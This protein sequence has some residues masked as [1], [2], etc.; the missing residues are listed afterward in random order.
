VGIAPLA[1]SRSFRRLALVALATPLVAAIIELVASPWSHD[2][3]MRVWRAS[4]LG[5]PGAAIALGF[6]GVLLALWKPVRPGTLRVEER[7]LVVDRG[8]DAR[9]IPLTSIR[10]GVVVP[11]LYGKRARV[12]ITL[13]SGDEVI[14]EVE[15]V[16]EGA[17]LLAEAGIDA[18]RRRSSIPLRSP[19]KSAFFR[20]GTILA[21][22]FGMFVGLGVLIGAV[23]PIRPVFIPV[24]LFTTA[25]S[26][27]LAAHLMR[28]RSITV[29]ADGLIVP[30][31]FRDAFVPFS[32]ITSVSA[33]RSSV[34]ITLHD[35]RAPRVFS[36]DA[37]AAQTIALRVREAQAA[38][39]EASAAQAPLEQLTRGDRPVS[40]WR[41]A[42]TRLL[43]T[44]G[45][46]RAQSFSEDDLASLIASHEAPA[47]QRLGAALALAASGDE[48]RERVRI[49]AE[50][51]ASPTMRVALSTIASGEADEQAIEEALAEEAAREGD[52]ETQKSD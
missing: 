1:A 42:A 24:W 19:A 52:R 11:A 38:S 18:A 35:Q 3:W 30:G 28:A 29:G 9:R 50:A 10:S 20:G 45:D 40:A 23:G 33:E 48:P 2:T 49:A 51:C 46:Y 4:L 22:I 31:L 6:V 26:A 21:T 25:A 12:E 47:E 34:D 17:R 5:G 41:E 13:A 7:V 16:A 44:R 36:A 37:E 39:S 15:S 27:W 14:A 32:S 43:A 8:G